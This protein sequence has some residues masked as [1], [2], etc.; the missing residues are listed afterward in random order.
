MA[1]NLWGTV[2]AWRLDN[3]WQLPRKSSAVVHKVRVE[4]NLKIV[5]DF[6]MRKFWAVLVFWTRSLQKILHSGLR[7]G[8]DKWNYYRTDK[9]QFYR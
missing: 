4:F 2:C 1:G 3:E 9:G 5:V 6:Q 7:G 8:V